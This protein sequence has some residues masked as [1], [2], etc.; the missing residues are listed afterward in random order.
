[1]L[2]G[3]FSLLVFPPKIFFDFLPGKGL[4]FRPSAVSLKEKKS[5]RKEKK[6]QKQKK[7]KKSISPGEI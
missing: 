7:K 1:M 6:E 3:R 5:L 4:C 2:A